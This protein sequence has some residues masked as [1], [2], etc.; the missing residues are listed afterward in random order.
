M[1]ADPRLLLA[2]PADTHISG[3]LDQLL[4]PDHPVRQLRTFVDSL[5]L[6]EL[7][8]A[9]RSVEGHPGAPAIDPRILMALW[10]YAVSQGIS[11]S[12]E[13]ETLCREH[14]A[15]RWIAGG[16][17]VGYH[18]L[19]DFRTGH[20]AVLERLLTDVVAVMM[21]EGLIDLKRVAQD[22]MR[23]RAS[24]GASSFHREPT[25]ERCHEEAK[26][27]V[28]ALRVHEGEDQGA[29]NRRSLA[30]RERAA[31]ERLA[32][33]NA[34]KGELEQLR[35][36]NADRYPSTRKEEGEIR[37]STTDP[38]ARKMKMPDGG[39]RPAFNV[40]FATTTDGGVVVG[41]SVTNEGNDGSQLVPMLDQIA[42]DHGVRPGEVLVD[43]G[44]VTVEGID[45]TERSGTKVYAPVK[46]KQK[47][48]KK[49]KEQT[50][51]E[52]SEDPFSRK[53]SD[54]DATARWRARMGTEEA[55][56]IYRERASTAEW[57]NAGA[58]N[59][60]MYGVSVRGVGKVLILAL[61]Q[62]LAHNY[63]RLNALRRASEGSGARGQ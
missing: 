25:L 57:V 31:R 49:Q 45:T 47:K 15:Y 54:T 12:R 3:T 36:D 9:I 62:A 42:A 32:R 55:G 44:Y 29:A 41:V 1:N 50:K 5:D 20:G 24:A 10:L 46:K 60:G 11:S 21:K 40:Q 58:R 7:L 6:A 59:R 61:W 22:G 8:G 37:V 52:S 34:A 38:E 39:T 35:R 23:V 63:G 51:T 43:G 19:A 27:Q 56:V 16:V 14:L 4:P 13:I 28:E 53:K 2:N 48:Q 18:T 33:L 26:Q 17:H 30:A